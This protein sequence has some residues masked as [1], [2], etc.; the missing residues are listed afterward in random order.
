MTNKHES[1]QPNISENAPPPTAVQPEG[2]TE[3]HDAKIDDIKHTKKQPS[4]THTGKINGS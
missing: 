1:T 2:G 4:G 3:H